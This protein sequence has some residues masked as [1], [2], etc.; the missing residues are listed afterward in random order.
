MNKYTY[1]NMYIINKFILCWDLSEKLS[2]MYGENRE[3]LNSELPHF[4]SKNDKLP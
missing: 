1:I 4:A 2:V 3:N